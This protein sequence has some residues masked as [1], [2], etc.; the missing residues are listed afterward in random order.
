MYSLLNEAN[1]FKI[2]FKV[3]EQIHH[4]PSTSALTMLRKK[5]KSN[6]LDQIHKRWQNK[7]LHGKLVPN[8][9]M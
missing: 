3:D 8:N 4:N 6:A 1:K 5:A 9:P 2:E 7:Q